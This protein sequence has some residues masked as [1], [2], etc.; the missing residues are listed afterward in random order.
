[1]NSELSDTIIEDI[2]EIVE[3]Q[4]LLLEGELAIDTGYRSSTFLSTINPIAMGLAAGQIATEQAFV[5]LTSMVETFFN[6]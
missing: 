1:M 5:Q 4:H 6:E 2:N 3:Q